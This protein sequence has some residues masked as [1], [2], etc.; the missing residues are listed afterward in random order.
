MPSS[1]RVERT[2]ASTS[3]T[4]GWLVQSP[5]R[6]SGRRSASRASSSE[7]KAARRLIERST[8]SIPA[9]SGI[10]RSP[11]EAPMNTFTPQQPGMRSSSPSSAAFS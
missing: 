11:V 8:A 5:S 6:A 7:W 4:S 3:R 9:S 2:A 10:S 1:R